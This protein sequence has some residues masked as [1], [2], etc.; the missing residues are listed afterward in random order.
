MV[1]TK[2]YEAE[3]TIAKS[4]AAEDLA[5]KLKELLAARELD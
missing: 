5:G 1:V 3:T 2:A 4:E